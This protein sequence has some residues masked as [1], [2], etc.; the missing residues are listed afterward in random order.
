MLQDALLLYT[1]MVLDAVLDAFYWHTD[2]SCA[3]FQFSCC[4]S[5]GCSQR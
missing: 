5:G 1:R 4:G 3:F 2:S